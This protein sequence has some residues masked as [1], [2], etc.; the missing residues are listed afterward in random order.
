MKIIL[1]RVIIE[2]YA[3]LGNNTGEIPYTPRLPSPMVRSRESVVQYFNQDADVGPILGQTPRVL[4]AAIC[5][6]VCGSSIQSV[7]ITSTVHV[8][9]GR[10]KGSSITTGASVVHIPLR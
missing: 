1:L 7:F 8:T 5:V 9:T 2:S 3:V 4:H 6:Q 10:I